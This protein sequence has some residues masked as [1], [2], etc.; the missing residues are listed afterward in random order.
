MRKIIIYIAI[1]LDGK[2]ADANGGVAWLDDIPN[3]EKTDYGYTGFHKT[4]D[5]TIMGNKTYQQV[6]GF[7]V[8][9]PYMD[10][11]NYVITRDQS[12]KSDEHVTFISENIVAFFHELKRKPGKNIWCI[13]GGEL[14]ALM[15]NHELIDELLIFIMP[16]ILGQGIPLTGKINKLLNL[17]LIKNRSYNSGVIEL[18]YKLNPGMRNLRR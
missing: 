1:S 17:E 5:T 9:F 2:I 18:R 13:G 7:D 15:L 4:I 8:K 11:K 3:P 12:L 14:I 10:T 6:L 16:V